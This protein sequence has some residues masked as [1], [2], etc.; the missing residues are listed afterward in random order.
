MLGKAGRVEMFSLNGRRIVPLAYTAVYWCAALTMQFSKEYFD[1][2]G[3]L[4]IRDR[5][6]LLGAILAGIVA[7][8][9][10]CRIVRATTSN[11]KA[12]IRAVR[13]EIP[14]RGVLS[15]SLTI[16]LFAAIGLSLAVHI[17]ETSS[18]LEGTD[19]LVALLTGLLLA[20]ATSVL[21]YLALRFVAE[22]IL[23]LAETF[24]NRLDGPRLLA[25]RYLNDC[26]CHPFLSW[27]IPLFNRPPPAHA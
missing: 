5:L 26:V 16:S 14:T 20:I 8:A 7:I 12:T 10:I 22:V 2:A 15:P 21:A 9:L 1:D 17:G 3:R 27:P 6:L 4:D 24:V 25:A 23:F 13:Q 19:A 11:D 18:F